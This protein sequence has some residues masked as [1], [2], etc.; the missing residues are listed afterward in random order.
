MLAGT[1]SRL[2]IL[3]WTASLQGG[4]APVAGPHHDDP[5]SGTWNVSFQAGDQPTPA[6]FELKLDGTR[7]TGMVRSDHT[8]TGQ[9]TEGSWAE[10]KLSFVAVFKNHES[11]AITG[12]LEAEKLAGEFRTEGFVATWEATRASASRP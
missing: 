2:A 7:V 9:V 10:G 11:I 6:T 4:S 3:V 12:T 8:G 5:I 1:F